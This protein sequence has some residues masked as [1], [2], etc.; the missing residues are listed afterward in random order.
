MALRWWRNVVPCNDI[1]QNGMAQVCAKTQLGAR[2]AFRRFA[3]SRPNRRT[4]HR[5]RHSLQTFGWHSGLLRMGSPRDRLKAKFEESVDYVAG[6]EALRE[7]D[8]R[9]CGS[10]VSNDGAQLQSQAIPMSGI[11]LCLPKLIKQP[12]CRGRLDRVKSAYQGNRCPVKKWQDLIRDEEIVG[13]N[14]ISITPA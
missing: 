9:V 7:N 12:Q 1:G 14:G 10:S 3:R 11:T 2:S 13:G 4:E 8:A 6:D 5:S